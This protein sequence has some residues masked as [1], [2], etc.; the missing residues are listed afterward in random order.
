MPAPI[1]CLFHKDH[2]W[3]RPTN[4]D[5]VLIGISDFAQD[6]LG[7]IM[8]FDLPEAGARIVAGES[9]GAVESIKVVNE[10]IAP[11]SGTVLRANPIVDAEPNRA[12]SDPYGEGWLIVVRAD[13]DVPDEL[14][15]E[16]NYLTLL[17]S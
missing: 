11:V 5:D 6:S 17:R 12:N 3:C 1:D 16:E 13:S 10:L 8:Y 2:L 14:M 4:E 9:F 15:S 7:E